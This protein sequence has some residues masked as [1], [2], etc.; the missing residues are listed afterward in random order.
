MNNL[1][2]RI[3]KRQKS[4]KE[5]AQGLDEGCKLFRIKVVVSLCF[6]KLSTNGLSEQYWN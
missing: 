1:K 6:D 5:S 3:A 2:K 4:D